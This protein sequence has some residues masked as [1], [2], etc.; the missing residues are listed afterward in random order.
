MEI[1]W[2]GELEL[3]FN[4]SFLPF[5]GMTNTLYTIG[6][7]IKVSREGKN[8]AL[9]DLEGEGTHYTVLPFSTPSAIPLADPMILCINAQAASSGDLA[10]GFG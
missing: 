7:L 6:P 2:L 3:T 4:P 1:R 9:R 8:S 5:P 10:Q